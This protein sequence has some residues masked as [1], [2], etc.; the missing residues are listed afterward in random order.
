[1][2]YSLFGMN[3]LTYYYRKVISII[4]AMTWTVLV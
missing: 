2:R 1:M 4:L 3:I